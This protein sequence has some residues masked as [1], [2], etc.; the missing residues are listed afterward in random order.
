MNYHVARYTF[1][2]DAPRTVDIDALLPSFHPFRCTEAE[3]E[4]LFR[5]T[6]SESPLPQA[7][8]AVLWETSVNDMGYTRLLKTAAG[9]RVELQAIAQGLTH[10]MDADAAFTTLT[11]FIRREDPYRGEALS[12]LLRIAYSQAVLLHGGISVHA[13]SVAADGGAYMFMGRS[14]TGKSTHA[15]M[16]MRSF[17]HCELLNDDNP[18]VCLQAD[19]TPYIYGTPWSGKTPCYRRAGY[20]LKG[21]ALLRQAPYNR[22]TACLD[23]EAF[24]AVLPGCS[25]IQKDSVLHRALCRTLASMVTAVP[26]GIMECLPDKEAAAVSRNA[27]FNGQE[28][29]SK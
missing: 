27:F 22:F 10:C 14:G 9:Y 25:V 12:S 2:V 26:V 21:I 16:W 4:K 5:L 28:T 1:T 29:V 8:E 17:P 20:P 23:D 18:T 19:G 13:S 3:G 11:A 24:I 15:A 6:L 7:A